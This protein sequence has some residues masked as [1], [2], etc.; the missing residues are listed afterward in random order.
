MVTLVARHE[1][2]GLFRVWNI[3]VEGPST[4]RTTFVAI[5]IKFGL[6]LGQFISKIPPC[7]GRCVPEET[8]RCYLESIQ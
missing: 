3:S 5:E 1:S 4:S 8:H 6:R 7:H 2:V